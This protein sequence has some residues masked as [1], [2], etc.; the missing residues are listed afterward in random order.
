M[1]KNLENFAGLAGFVADPVR[2]SSSQGTGPNGVRIF[3]ARLALDLRPMAASGL[4]L[5]P[6]FRVQCNQRAWRAGSPP[7]A[8]GIL[9]PGRGGCSSSVARMPEPAPLLMEFVIQPQALPCCM[10]FG[11]GGESGEIRPS[12]RHCPL[13]Q[14][15]AGLIT[16]V[17]SISK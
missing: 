14:L 9:A 8:S 3:W 7:T 13:G 4:E 15:R 10:P 6:S 11:L 12:A 2:V 1:H 5:A 17:T 16:A